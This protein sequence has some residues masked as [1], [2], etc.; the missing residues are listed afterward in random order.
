MPVQFA[1]TL[2]DFMAWLKM[3]NM[4]HRLPWIRSQSIRYFYQYTINLK[5]YECDIY[6]FVNLRGQN[7]YLEAFQLNYQLKIT[8]VFLYSKCGL[9]NYRGVKKMG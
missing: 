5:L 4:S 6:I 1:A 7:K 8:V 9:K 3:Y 2:K